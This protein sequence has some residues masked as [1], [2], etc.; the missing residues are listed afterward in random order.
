MNTPRILPFLLLAA[1]IACAQA[2]DNA[3]A[4]AQAEMQKWIATTDAQWQAVFKRDVTDVHEAELNKVKLQYLTSLETGIAKASGA[5]DLNGAVALRNEQK[6]FG[7]TNVFPEKD[8]AADAASVKQL[9]TAIRAQLAKLEKDTAARTRALHAKYDAVLAQAQTQLTQ[10]QRLDDAL[11]VK[12]KRDEVAAAWLTGIPVQAA[13]VAMAE[14]PKPQ[15]PA[16][17]TK[18]AAKPTPPDGQA[19]GSIP[20][21]ALAKVLTPEQLQIANGLHIGKIVLPSRRGLTYFHLDT[22]I[23]N[24]SPQ[25]RIEKQITIE[26][27]VLCVD[28]DRKLNVT[29]FSKGLD[30]AT[31]GPQPVGLGGVVTLQTIKT[32]NNN[33]EIPK[34]A[35]VAFKIGGVTFHEAFLSS[36]GND[37]WW[38]QDN[39]IVK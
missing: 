3:A 17:D 21:E 29:R 5:N 14:Q 28:G 30:I 39:L 16:P 11:L 10:R 32:R 6:R 37:K 27:W 24:R 4:P 34:N 23:D 26:V 12:T 13:A 9:R 22:Q 2:Q 31:K 36:P 25:G 18:A 20:K 7:D 8:E 15:V 35:R 19:G 38:L 33:S 1:C